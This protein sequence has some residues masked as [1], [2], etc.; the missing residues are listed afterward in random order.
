MTKVVIMAGGK[1]TRLMPLTHTR[2]KPMCMIGDKPILQH[3]IENL[4][5]QGFEEFILTLNYRKDEVRDYFKDGSEFGVEIKYSIENEPL[6]TAGGVKLVQ[7]NVDETFAVVS[8]DLFTN[9]DLKKQLD[10]HKM[11]KGLVTMGMLS[12]EDPTHFGVILTDKAGKIT[13]FLEKPK[14]REEAFSDTINAGI[15]VLEPEVLDYVPDKEPY[16]F[17]KNLFP[18]LLS[19]QKKLYGFKE[20]K[21]WIDIG[22]PGNYLKALEL[23]MGEHPPEVSRGVKLKGSVWIGEDFELHNGVDV[24]GPSMIL[25][26][27]VIGSGSKIRKSIIYPNNQVGSDTHMDYSIVGCDSQI[28]SDCRIHRES[29]IGDECEIGNKVKIHEGSKIWPRQK[30]SHGAEVKGEVGKEES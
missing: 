17:S 16:D 14:T 10:F 26:G 9:W 29:I 19:K 8:G 3:T 21:L 24:E 30:V 23:A 20:E 2:P 18:E 11:K 15:Y 4:K 6:G 5:K 12:V 7:K 13:K 22:L 25:K 27:S 28:G 1:G